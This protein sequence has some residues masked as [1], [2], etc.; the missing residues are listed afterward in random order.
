[1]NYEFTKDQ[2]MIRQAARDFLEAECPK[3]KIRHL[4]QD[5]KGYDPEM[6]KKMVE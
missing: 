4:R 2:D 6:W 5:P 1:M 3:E